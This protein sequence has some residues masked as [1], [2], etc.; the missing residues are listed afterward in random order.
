MR[1]VMISATGARIIVGGK[2]SNYFGK[3]PGVVEEALI[4]VQHKKPLY[5]VGAMG[6]ATVQVIEALN[7]KPFSF[8]NDTY[9]TSA[10]YIEFKNYY[11]GKESEG[12][13]LKAVHGTF[14]KARVKSLAAMN[15]LTV[16]E[17]ERL[18]RTPHLSEIIYLIF[19]G[20]ST[21]S[22]GK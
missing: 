18:F 6:G 21:I 1:N 20:L 4:A 8:V 17:N 7:G 15:G 14:A 9:H 19:K 13:D 11:N 16:E 10:E 2:T 5:L 22:P 3:M 12:I